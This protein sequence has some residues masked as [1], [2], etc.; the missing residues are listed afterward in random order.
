MLKN[1]VFLMMSVLLCLFACACA[2][3][4]E[5]CA[6]VRIRVLD[7]F[8][9]QPICGAKVVFAETEEFSYTDASGSTQLMRVPFL[10]DPQYEA[11]L[12]SGKGRITLIAY[13]GGYLPYVLSYMRVSPGEV[14]DDITLY[15][16][17]DDGSIPVFSIIEGPDEDWAA[18]LAEKFSGCG[19]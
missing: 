9:E 15:M 11:L 18:G 2:G 7:A 12:P 4:D 19:N 5:E 1:V 14:R 8:T 16:F 3:G 6:Y 10:L 13:S 17:K